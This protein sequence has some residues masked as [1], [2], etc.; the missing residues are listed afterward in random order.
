MSIEI[1]ELSGEL[2]DDITGNIIV[3]TDV[4]SSYGTPYFINFDKFIAFKQDLSK[5]IDCED[6][7]VSGNYGLIGNKDKTMVEININL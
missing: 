2:I 3:L 5:C 7:V 6:I 1:V 4:T